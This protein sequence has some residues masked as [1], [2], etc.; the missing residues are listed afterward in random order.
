M[1]AGQLIEVFTSVQGEGP[2]VGFRQLFV[3]LAG[4]NLDC[5]YCDTRF[6]AVPHCRFET[7][8]GTGRF[9]PLANPVSAQDLAGRIAALPL[10]EYHSVS[11]TGGEPLLQHRFLRE[12]LTVLRPRPRIYLE[13]NGTLVAELENVISLCDIVAMDIKLPSVSGRPLPETHAPFLKVAA[14][15]EVFVKTVVSDQTTSAEMRR[16]VGLIHSIDDRIPLI[17]QPVTVNGRPGPVSG[18]RLLE[19]Q[20]LALE[21]LT[22]VRVIPQTHHI[23]GVL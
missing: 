8:A 15:R 4:C 2:Y 22:N 10:E 16:A 19:L 7:V 21:Q 3:R 5:A 6:Q 23:T 1:T 12:V 14:K 13:T 9:E 11:F 18:T 17:I 20:H